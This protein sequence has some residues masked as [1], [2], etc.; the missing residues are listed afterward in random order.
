[1]SLIDAMSENFILMDKKRT[2]DGEG[3]YITQWVEGAQISAALTLDTSMQARIAESQGVTSV[4]TI[5]TGREVMLEYHDVLKRVSDGKIFRV[6][7][8]GG[9]KMTPEVTRLNISQVKAE[10]WELP[11]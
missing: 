10:S 11:Q 4:Y 6:T 5:T 7:S 2:S 8:N 1:M 9:E 3:G